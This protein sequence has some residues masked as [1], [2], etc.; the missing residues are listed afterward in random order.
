MEEVG[1]G[2]SCRYIPAPGG[3]TILFDPAVNRRPVDVL[4]KR[5]DVVRPLETVIEHEGVLEHV[6]DEE[7]IAA[8]GMGD[9]MFVDP[10][11]DEPVGA[12]ILVQNDPADAA[13]G[14]GG[15]EILFPGFDAPK[16][17]CDC[18]GGLAVLA[19]AALVAEVFKVIFMKPHTVEFPA[20][21]AL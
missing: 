19:E 7:G 11:I 8:R 6:H 5:L 12:C 3:K 18:L 2:C 15:P 9:V 10:E 13:H 14:A 17:C 4:E 21:P 1:Q 20:Q 16:T